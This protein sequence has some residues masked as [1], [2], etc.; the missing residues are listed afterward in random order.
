MTP[1]LLIASSLAARGVTDT[2]CPAPVAISAELLE[3]RKANYAP[4][5]RTM[6]PPPAA[7]AA[8]YR[9]AYMEARKTD[10]ADLCQFRADNIRLLAR[11]QAER[12]VVFMGDSIT[13]NWALADPAFYSG[14][15]VNRGISGQTTPQML[16]RFPADVLA[17]HPRVVH[18]MAGTND[19]AGN[20]GPTTLDT[21]VGNIH[22]M[23]VLA[24]AA[25]IRVVLAATPPS[26]GF[27]WATELKPALVIAALNVRLR[28]VAAREHVTFVDYGAILATP[29]GALKPQ[30]TFDGTHPN[31]N[32]YAAIAPLARQTIAAAQ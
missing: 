11:P 3:W 20:T 14:G 5:N 18:I 1:L 28:E 8:A 12:D 29:D 13:Q 27:N 21:I 31:S 15:R 24:K 32:G 26:A 6:L 19:V 7:A 16:V 22:A 2:P 10:W 4:G 9:A 30:Y 25:G 23:V 17:L